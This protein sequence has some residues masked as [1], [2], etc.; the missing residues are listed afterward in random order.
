[1]NN[2]SNTTAKV[3]FLA[4]LTATSLDCGSDSY[5]IKNSIAANTLSNTLPFLSSNSKTH[6]L[7]LSYS[8]NSSRDTFQF[9][10]N[11]FE[12]NFR[13]RGFSLSINQLEVINISKELFQNTIP[14]D[15]EM[16]IALNRAI[17]STGRK[18]PTLPNRL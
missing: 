13:E 4:T 11:S 5:N 12:D 18:K 14:M 15:N 7:N 17:I 10:L 6:N 1:M 16:L 9:D 2:Q 8:T 3:F